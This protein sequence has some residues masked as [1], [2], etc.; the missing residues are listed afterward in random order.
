MSI[1]RPTGSYARQ[2]LDPG[3]WVEADEDTFYDRAQEYSQVLQR[4][5]DVL[6]TCRQQKGHVFEGGLCPAAPPMLPTAPWVQ[7]SIN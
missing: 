7:T 3:G 6:D 1:T 4:V 5:T 2:M